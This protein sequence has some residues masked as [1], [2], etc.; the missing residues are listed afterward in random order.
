V[1]LG[2]FIANLL[3]VLLVLTSVLMPIAH[4]Q[5]EYQK[6]YSQVLSMAPRITFASMVAYITAQTHDIYAFHFW[7]RVTRGRYLW[8]RNNA[9]TIVSQGIDTIIFSLIAFLYLIPFNSLLIMMLTLWLVK[10]LIAL[11]DTPFCYLGCVI[12][13][14]KLGL[15]TIWEKKM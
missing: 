12:I 5:L 9:S 4:F 14:K 7:G 10:L 2:G 8:V 1:V 6:I 13:R 15:Q 3:M 11:L